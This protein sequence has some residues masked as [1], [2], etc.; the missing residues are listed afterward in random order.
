MKRTG[1]AAIA[2][3][4]LASAGAARAATVPAE[5]IRD[6]QTAS[7]QLEQAAL[8]RNVASDQTEAQ[9]LLAARDMLRDAEPYLDWSQ[10]L[11]A[12]ML[13]H[14]IGRDV[15]VAD[16]ADTPLPYLPIPSNATARVERNDLSEL[17][18]RGVDLAQ[19]AADAG[20]AAPV[21]GS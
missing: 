18:R 21:A 2:V 16:D 1:F 17:A 14:E 5:A 9:H 3:A 7:Q 13:E 10:R 15:R 20:R 6:L 8:L 4:A 12:K 11:Q 19:Q